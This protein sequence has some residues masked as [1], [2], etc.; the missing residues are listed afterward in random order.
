M[1]TGGGLLPLPAARFPRGTSFPPI[2][3]FDFR[4]LASLASGS[5][6]THD[7]PGGAKTVNDK[8]PAKAGFS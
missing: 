1:N 4:L 8:K 2:P 6:M 3:R 5:G 7:R